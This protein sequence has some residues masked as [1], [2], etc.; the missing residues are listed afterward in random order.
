MMKRFNLRKLAAPFSYI[1][2]KI[3]ELIQLPPPESPE[4]PLIEIGKIRPPVPLKIRIPPDS[5]T[6]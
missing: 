6:L 1:Y 4:E 3:R 5:Q 2:R